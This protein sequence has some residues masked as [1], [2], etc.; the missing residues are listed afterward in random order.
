MDGKFDPLIAKIIGK[1]LSSKL[2]IN[3]LKR[4]NRSGLYNPI[5]E[6]LESNPLITTEE[7]IEFVKKLNTDGRYNRLLDFILGVT[8]TL[9]EGGN[10]LEDELIRMKNTG[11][12][13]TLFENISSKSINNPRSL[14]KY[15]ES[16][17]E[18]GKYDAL[19]NMIKNYLGESDEIT[20]K[21]PSGTKLTI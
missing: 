12:F 15:L 17:N 19:I 3:I 13:E 6:Y 8:D 7:L 1:K 18:D 4:N 14:L 11:N 2:L 10:D 20:T 16:N 21:I 9:Q 5:I